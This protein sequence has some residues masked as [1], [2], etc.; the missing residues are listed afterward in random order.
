MCKV[1]NALSVVDKM[2]RISGKA[3]LC[4][5]IVQDNAHQRIYIHP[6]E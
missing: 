3:A 5:A 2:T 6:R 1:K 4:N